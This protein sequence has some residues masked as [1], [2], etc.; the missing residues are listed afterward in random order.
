MYSQQFRE[1]PNKQN[2]CKTKITA[3]IYILLQR[4]F[5]CG[6]YIEKSGNFYILFLEAT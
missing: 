3:F 5:S 6:L 4:L 2:I 1:I